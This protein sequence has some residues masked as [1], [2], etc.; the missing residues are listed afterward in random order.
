MIRR[1][2][3]NRVVVCGARQIWIRELAEHRARKRR[4]RNLGAGWIDAAGSR[5][6]NVD[7]E[8]ALTLQRAWQRGEDRRLCILPEA[9]IVAEEERTVLHNR[10]AADRAVLI[11]AERR[12]LAVWW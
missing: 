5:I 11:P 4:H 1:V 6:A 9:F 12:L 10:T 7:S 3:Q 8:N 2:L